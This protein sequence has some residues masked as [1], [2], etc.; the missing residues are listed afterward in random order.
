MASKSK[1]FDAGSHRLVTT[2]HLS[3]TNQ[4]PAPPFLLLSLLLARTNRVMRPDIK[5]MLYAWCSSFLRRSV[6]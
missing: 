5:D 4:S 1:A 3:R 6:N 2:F